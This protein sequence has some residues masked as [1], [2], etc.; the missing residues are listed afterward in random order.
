MLRCIVTLFTLHEWSARLCLNFFG[1]AMRFNG[2]E[3]DVAWQPVMIAIDMQCEIETTNEEILLDR[4]VFEDRRERASVDGCFMLDLCIEWLVD[5][6]DALLKTKIGIAGL[7]E[8]AEIAFD[9]DRV[10]L[11][12]ALV[13][14]D[15]LLLDLDVDA[16]D[17]K[18]LQLDLVPETDGNNK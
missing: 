14:E 12:G 18:G 11:V 15:S 1:V 10:L 16:G 4:G 7:F 6:E 17:D 8:L 3:R 9:H 5:N 13:T 2:G